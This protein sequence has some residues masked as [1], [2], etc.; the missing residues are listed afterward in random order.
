[1][2]E[3]G[4]RL[5]GE[6]DRQFQAFEIYASGPRPTLQEVAQET[7]VSV[8][9]IKA[10]AKKYSWKQRIQAREADLASQL[11]GRALAQGVEETERNLK[12]VRLAIG[13]VAKAISNEQVKM[14]MTDLESLIRMEEHLLGKPD[15]PGEAGEQSSPERAVIYIPDNGRGDVKTFGPP[16]PQKESDNA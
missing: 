1:M 7:G 12:I 10:W 14:S 16:P 15:A 9:T 8:R 6:R 13:R 5:P 4:D 2:P 11:A 3:P